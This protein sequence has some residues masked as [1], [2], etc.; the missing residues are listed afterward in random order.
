M[1]TITGI[2]LAAAMLASYGCFDMPSLH[3]IFTEQTA[4]AEPRLVGAWESMDGKEQMFVKLSG[5]CE[6]RLTYLDDEGEA[7]LWEL[8][9][10]KVGDALVADMMAIRDDSTMIPAHHLFA[11][12]FAGGSLKAWFLDSNQ[13][14]EKAV[15]EGLAYIRAKDKV[16]MTAS[17]ESITAF[18]KKNLADEMKGKVDKE[19]QR[20]K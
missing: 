13:L 18:L 16:V 10:V 15:K 3:P 19:F 7:S 1:K 14:R 8:H 5:D 12:S 2:L 6:Y 4:I 11:L 9:V 20:L 17:A